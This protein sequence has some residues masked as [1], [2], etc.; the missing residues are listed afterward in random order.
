MF[1]FRNLKIILVVVYVSA[2]LQVVH[3]SNVIS[4][5]GEIVSEE[6]FYSLSIE[7]SPGKEVNVLNSAFHNFNLLGINKTTE[8]I[9]ND[10]IQIES[11]FLSSDQRKLEPDKDDRV[12]ALLYPQGFGTGG[13]RN[14]IIKFLSFITYAVEQKFE[15]ILH[16][17]L[18][19][20]TKINGQRTPIPFELLFDVGFWNAYNGTDER[21]QRVPKL[22]GYS[23]DGN[24]TCWLRQN[25]TQK[26][27][28]QEKIPILE[29]AISRGFSKLVY[30]KAVGIATQ[31]D[32][33]KFRA[34]DVL[35]QAQNC[36]GRPNVYGGGR[37][38]GRLWKS[39]METIRLI[40]KKKRQGQNIEYPYR[41]DEEVTKALIPRKEWRDLAMTCIPSK[42]YMSIHVR[43]EMDMIS[44]KC[45]KTMSKN[46][47][48]LFHQVEDL[49]DSE[50]VKDRIKVDYVSLA[51]HRKEMESKRGEG[52]NT[53][54]EYA[55][56]NLA[57]LNH[58][59]QNGST[60]NG[61]N[62]LSNRAV[63]ECGHELVQKYYLQNPNIADHGDILDS[64]INFYILV[65]SNVFIGVRNSSF[66]AGVWM[67]RFLLGK[68]STNYEY[69]S[70]GIMPLENG[71]RP[72]EHQ[73]C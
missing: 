22:V 17:S 6:I 48:K 44:H 35:E 28:N 19:F 42:N 58:Y 69:T 50:A 46:L 37:Q 45:G 57:V 10:Q 4:L 2:L 49:L 5:Q 59:T 51:L 24:Y 9:S 72:P 53:Y 61:I 7:L 12:L 31:K 3:L 23:E 67:A 40:H 36:V 25:Y 66:S 68:G 43:M 47:T 39:Y 18:Q 33:S 70:D 34:L 20:E 27:T 26:N 30:D 16:D 65:H 38:G 8:S 13:Y 11:K 32:H 21:S 29:Q 60:A 55:I 14:Q 63:I 64:I 54:K 1:Q 56:E 52:Y 71:G 73:A 41:L 62:T 15:Y